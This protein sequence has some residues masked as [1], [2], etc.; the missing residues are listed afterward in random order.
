MRLSV[1]TAQS[2]EELLRRLEKLSPEKRAL[3]ARKLRKKESGPQI[4]G[5]PRDGRTFPVSYAQQRL[6]FLERWE[7]GNPAYIQLFSFEFTGEL[8]LDL[9]QQSLNALILRHEAL[10]TVFLLESGEPRQRVLQDLPV[11]VRQIDLSNASDRDER[12]AAIAVE[13]ARKPFDLA[14]GPLQ[15][16]LL[17]RLARDR[18]R[19]LLTMHHIITDGWSATVLTDELCALYRSLHDGVPNSLT[20]LPIQY[21]D[22]AAWQRDWLA[23]EVM[24]RQLA[25][26]RERL[27]PTPPII[28]LPA[29]HARP[30]EQTYRGAREWLNLPAELAHR[31][32]ALAEAEGATPFMVLLTAFQALVLRW[33]G[34]PDVVV[35]SAIANRNLV[36]LEPLIGYFSNTLVL[37]A[38]LSGEPT[39]REALRRV[40]QMVIAAQENQDVPFEK[41]VEDLQPERDLSRSPLFQLMF[42]LMNVPSA[43]I[44][45]PGARVK[46]EY[47]FDNGST[48]FDLT[49][50]IGEVRGG[51]AATCEYATDLFEP[52][53]MRRLLVHYRTLLDEA[54]SHPDA[55]ITRLGFL[56]AEEHRQ[57][58]DWNATETGHRN[59][60]C[61]HTL[62]AE[63]A[64][65]RPEAIAV[66]CGEARLTYGELNSAANRLAHFLI[67]QGVRPDD[68]VAL[69]VERSV[70]MVVGLLGILKSGGAYV[71]LDPTYPRE[72][73][74][75]ILE[76]ACPS[77]LITTRTLEPVLPPHAVS[78]LRLDEADL[79]G[80]PD[81]DPDVPIGP[82][83]LAYTIFTSGSTGRPKGVMVP[84]GNVVHL[85]E[86]A[87][88]IFD[89]TV[90]DCWTVFHSFSFDFSV[91]EI[92]GA[93]LT[94][95]TLVVATR[96]E[97]QSPAL[98][99]A[100]VRRHG[101][102]V[103]NLTP[104][105]H[106][107]LADQIDGARDGSRGHEA[108]P[109]LRLLFTGGEALP[110]SL[111]PRLLAHGVPVW[112]FYGPTECTVWAAIHEVTP[113]DAEFA[114]VPVGRPLPDNHLY[115]LDAHQQLLPIGVPGELCIGGPGVALGY[116][117]RPDL[118][119]ERFI[120]RDA[121]NPISGDPR[122]TIYRTGD[123]ARRLPDG[124]L[125]FLGRMDHQVK[126]RGFRIELGEIESAL[127]RNPLV[128]A[129]V[130]VAREDR[131][132][133]PRIVA[134]VEL[135]E[136]TEAA[137][138]DL[139]A[140]LQDVLPGYMIPSLV[141]VLPSLPLSPNGKVD[142]KALPAPDDAR[143]DLAAGYVAP[144]EE[145][146]LQLAGLWSEVLDVR[147]VGIHDNF[148]DLGGHS[149][150]A[151]RLFSEIEERLG[152]QLP[153]ATLFQAPTIA[154]LAEILRSDG[155]EPRWTSLVP[156]QPRGSKPPF[157][158]VHGGGGHVLFYR[159]LSARLGE[160]QPFYGLQPR[161][162]G[163]KHPPHTRIEDMA[164]HYIGEL[165]QVQ[166]HGPYYLGGA[167]YGG[168]IAFEMAQQ[169]TRAGEE[170]ATVLMFDTYGPGYPRHPWW[171]TPIDRGLG[172]LFRKVEHHAGSL[173]MLPAESRLP[174][175]REKAKKAIV[176][177][178]EWVDETARRGAR[179]LQRAMGAQVKIDEARGGM[180][181][182]LLAYRP[183]PYEG[184]VT[185]FRALRQPPNTL[186][187]RMLGWE[188][189]LPNGMHI[190]ETPGYHAAMISEP[191]VRFVAEKMSVWMDELYARH[192]GAESD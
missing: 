7:P 156:I 175:F 21:P 42:Q 53:T 9:L 68:R 71:P 63:H 76:D 91:W 1:E 115:V 92:W 155:W 186:F 143:P 192:A 130:A 19:L 153:L 74:A 142:R 122:D 18:H 126:I 178:W 47:Q 136:G 49:F 57:L 181:K 133:D 94:G 59:D 119:E 29:D 55:P 154:Q 43:E 62:V 35:G 33:T 41:I 166:P 132:G 127:A 150:L 72:R 120:R 73:V 174:Y 129:A 146:E 137:G 103:L 32:G 23:G 116:F 96:E 25:Y 144:K 11:E 13:E 111:A 164:S 40:R 147:Q 6:W 3:L 26:W 179:Q 34:Q 149:L 12:A 89:F 124:R 20:P 162:L 170:V 177:S 131:M 107:A 51:Y 80:Q 172:E 185:L 85:V 22:F 163:G 135:H 95:A 81:V 90:E 54:L 105:S 109:S 56:S 161:S 169:L 36:E 45:L 168:R 189:F 171:S 48:K 114:N 69:C 46:G 39:F 112:N 84:H 145:L 190:I 98:L 87:I 123:L 134:Y 16:A 183:Q 139:R 118:T 106:R 4:P 180:M 184:H 159:P 66:V 102:T 157:F 44:E 15:R 10:R 191:R 88:P 110:G 167:S 27:T 17:V 125:E 14:I 104:S 165:R 182:A 5:L 158:C 93:L 86:T 61:M 108:M 113:E 67:G 101:V 176:E 77:Y 79:A 58:R 70:E 30:A 37:R 28:D 65:R 60:R 148:F 78:T 83:N 117:G 140:G 141:I 128:A 100:A 52:A 151:V 24:Q 82:K 31:A 188:P 2:Q 138:G 97:T 187:D 8:R 173:Y 121:A 160:D 99:H 50:Q 64:R 75:A 38:D 152:K